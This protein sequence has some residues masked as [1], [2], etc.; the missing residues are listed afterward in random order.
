MP[1]DR[2]K[3]VIPPTEIA[4]GSLT[5][6]ASYVFLP[7]G[8]VTSIANT[9]TAQAFAAAGLQPGWGF[10]P[11]TPT[12]QTVQVFI[13]VP[14][15]TTITGGSFFMNTVMYPFT[16]TSLTGGVANAI[17]AGAAIA[18]PSG[19]FGTVLKYSIPAFSSADQ[20]TQGGGTVLIGKYFMP[21]LTATTWN[22]GT[23][24]ISVEMY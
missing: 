22:T 16:P 14:G 8:T 24:N 3:T 12:A 5:N 21:V 7:N 13:E 19:I 20:A 1:N 15:G 18:I 10:Y 23:F 9:T 6:G 17:A 11:I 2:F 4:L